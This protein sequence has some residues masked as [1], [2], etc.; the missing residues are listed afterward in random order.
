M[1]NIKNINSWLIKW[2][3]ENYPNFVYNMKNANHST[4]D[5]DL[6]PY[7]MEGDV[8]THTMMVMQ[9]AHNDTN[10]KVSLLAALLHDVGKPYV[11]EV[12][13]T[14]DGSKLLSYF[15]GHEGASFYL[16][17][18]VLNHL[19][20]LGFLNK[21]EK[22]QV[23]NTIGLHNI[24]FNLNEEKIQQYLPKFNNFYEYNLLL[25]QTKYDTQGRVVDDDVLNANEFFIE[26]YNDFVE[27]GKKY[28]SQ[29]ST[30]SEEEE[31]SI[32]L[33]VG[34]PG[35]GKSTYLNNM[36]D[37]DDAVII[38]RDN[39][40][41]K[42]GKE[43]YGITSYNEVWKKL[44]DNEHKKI[45]ETINNNFRKAVKERKNIIVDMTNLSNKS[46]RKWL[47]VPKTYSKKAIIFCT[48]F[49]TIFSRNLNRGDKKLPDDLIKSMMKR[50]TPPTYDV[51]NNIKWVF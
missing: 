8:W 39:E 3:T 26:G 21:E 37:V 34:V 6:N 4:N 5:N 19:E 50:F 49:D 15:T 35:T 11:R 47:N 46:R 22:I 1:K 41:Q 32:T 25:K 28:F 16:S 44:T 18:K 23:L 12:K 7:H 38:S 48:D 30:L 43:K 20:T 42:Y 45:D 9:E 13:Y 10:S 14:R 36:E 29:N 27:I 33:L 2:F 17:I 24:F 40:L 31:N 51:F